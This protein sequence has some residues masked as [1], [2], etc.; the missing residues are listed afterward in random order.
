MTRGANGK[1]KALERSGGGVG[2]T[3]WMEW[4]ED[5]RKDGKERVNRF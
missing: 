1:E 4:R 2:G 3:V 5:G